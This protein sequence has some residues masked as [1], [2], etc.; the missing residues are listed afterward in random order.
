MADATELEKVFAE[1]AAL[2]EQVDALKRAVVDARGRVNLSMREQIR[3]PHCGTRRI[4]HF[5]SIP[6]FGYGQVFKQGLV[7]KNRGFWRSGETEGH[8]EAYACT[9]C[10]AVEFWVSDTSL[11]ADDEGPFKLLTSEDPAA[12][13]YR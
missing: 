8:L 3:C 10:G 6:D 12:G 13:P 1:V 2:R 5:S 11:F 9:S 7:H 4:A